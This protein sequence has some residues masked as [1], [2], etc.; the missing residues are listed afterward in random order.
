VVLFPFRLFG[1]LGVDW[2]SVNS[3]GRDDPLIKVVISW[4]LFVSDLFGS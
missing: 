1:A 4:F 2:S 3:E